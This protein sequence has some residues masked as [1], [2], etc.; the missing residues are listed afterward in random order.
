MKFK[1]NDT[2][3]YQCHLSWIVGRRTAGRNHVTTNQRHA[4]WTRSSIP[5]ETPANRGP[6]RSQSSEEQGQPTRRGRLDW[7]GATGRLPVRSSDTQTLVSF[8]RCKWRHE[9]CCL[10]LRH[11]LFW[12]KMSVPLLFLKT[13]NIYASHHENLYY[14]KSVEFQRLRKR[15]GLTNNLRYRSFKLAPPKKHPHWRK[16]LPLTV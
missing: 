1:K 11:L 4:P 7:E 6:L 3:A 12:S 8:P 5:V 16:L 2:P 10:L 15:S 14:L 9:H 13:E